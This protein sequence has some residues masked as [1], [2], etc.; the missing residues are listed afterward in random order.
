MEH[1]LS[2]H[3]RQHLEDDDILVDFQHGFR[4]NRS[5]E[6]Q[7]I[8]T[9][10]EISRHLDDR[11]QVNLLILDFCKAFDTVPHQ[12]LLQ[13]LDHYGVRGNIH[14]WLKSWLTSREQEVVVDGYQST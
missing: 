10:E 13:K 5:C 7:L 8:I 2:K 14:G 1:I 11:Q 4:A 12:R 6:T 3:I 9:A